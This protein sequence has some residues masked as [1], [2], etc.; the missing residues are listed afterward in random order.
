MNQYSFEEVGCVN[1]D[2][3]RFDA[4]IRSGWDKQ[5]T[6]SRRKSPSQIVAFCTVYKIESVL[7]WPLI[8]DFL[9]KD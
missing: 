9:A 4:T 1:T 7:S 8:I 3:S 5:N 2:V 6:E